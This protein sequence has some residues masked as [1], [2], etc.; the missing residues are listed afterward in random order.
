[1]KTRTLAVLILIN[2]AYVVLGGVIF[3]FLEEDNEGDTR[4]VT[5]E[6]LEEFLGNLFSFSLSLVEL[7]E[8]RDRLIT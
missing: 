1:M 6:A 3:H 7:L 4:K 8:K 5:G 2:L